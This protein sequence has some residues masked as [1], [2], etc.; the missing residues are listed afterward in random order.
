[1][2][3][4]QSF[5]SADKLKARASKL[6][7]LPVDRGNGDWS[8]LLV[9]SDCGMSD[10]SSS[11]T[12]VYDFAARI[13]SRAFA[14]AVAL[15]VDA[16]L[17]WRAASEGA[18][19]REVTV[20]AYGAVEDRNMSSTLM[21]GHV[22]LAVAGEAKE[23]SGLSTEAPRF[24]SDIQACLCAGFEALNA[25]ADASAERDVLK[26]LNKGVVSEFVADHVGA[27]ARKAASCVAGGEACFARRRS[28]GAGREL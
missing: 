13:A 24:L 8:L 3:G 26:F 6:V 9:R 21:L 2:D 19:R 18:E 22:L 11:G 12:R 10:V 16:L 4:W 5:K 15:K 7:V 25:E 17:R 27:P 14:E 23:E 1:M 20:K 28:A